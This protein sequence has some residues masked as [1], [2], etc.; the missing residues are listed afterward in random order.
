MKLPCHIIESI[1]IAAFMLLSS[2]AC[3]GHCDAMDGP[4]V[5]AAQQ[6]LAENNVILALIWVKKDR[7]PEI[8]AA[9]EKTMAVRKLASDARELADAYFFETLVRVH[10]AGEGASYSG[11]KPAGRDLGPAIPAAERALRT[12]DIKPLRAMVSEEIG[13]GLQ[14]RFQEAA[15]RA[16]YDKSDAQAGRNFVESYT[17]FI[18][19]V[20]ALHQAAVKPVGHDGDSMTGLPK[21]IEFTTMPLR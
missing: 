14:V 2:S 17:E 21:N 5:Q 7:E 12:G 8:K 3:Y 4:V 13:R 10:L 9:F 6:A 18:H 19:Y 15:K 20:E 1:L 11:L 16:R